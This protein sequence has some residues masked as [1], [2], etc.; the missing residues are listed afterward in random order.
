MTA[1]EQ[2]FL[3]LTGYLGDPERKPLTVAQFREL[4]KRARAMERPDLDREMTPEDLIALGYGRTEALRIL[5]LL[6]QEEQLQ[7]YVGRGRKRGCTPVTRISP[8]YPEILRQRLGMEAPGA[9]W[10]KGDPE[11]LREPAVSLVGSRDLH[12]ENLEFA[13]EVG[14]Q[15]A[16]QGKVLVSGNARGADR[17]AQDSCLQHGGKVIVVVADELEKHTSRENVLYISEEGYELKFSAHRALN[18][19]RI[20]HC[21]GNCTL[22]AQCTYKKGGTWDGTGKNLRRGWSPVFCFRDDSRACREL[23]EM[24]AVSIGI[25]ALSDLDALKPGIC[26]LL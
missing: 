13:R 9:L 10:F 14:R 18:R 11:L 6:S 22:V 21:L 4:T 26:P 19:N 24:G 3:L 8:D 16:L 2:G 7:W 1:G 15:A 12:P 20:I 5:L 17:T 23:A 25:E